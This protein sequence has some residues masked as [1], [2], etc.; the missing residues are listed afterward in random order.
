M[1]HPR[2]HAD[3]VNLVRRAVSEL[4]GIALPYTVG[5]FKQM[6]GDRPV[7]IGKPG[8]SDIVAC[9]GGV[10]FGI[11]VKF[12]DKDKLRQDQEKFRDAIQLAGGKWV[13][14]DFRKGADGIE[15]VRQ[16]VHYSTAQTPENI[17][18]TLQHWCEHYGFNIGD[19][20]AS[21]LIQMLTPGF[22]HAG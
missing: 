9:I 2:N 1:K 21:H 5:M 3:A 13:L 18:A 11:E 10:F 7:R 17:D 14:A 20:P 8:V 22:R 16:G 19:G 12:S 6:D 4:G 15:A